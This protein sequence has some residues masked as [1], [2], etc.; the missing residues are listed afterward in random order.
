MPARLI[1]ARIL[2]VLVALGVFLLNSGYRLLPTVWLIVCIVAWWIRPR[3]RRVWLPLVALAGWVLVHASPY[4][5]S[6]QTR[7]GGPRFVELVMGYPSNE[8]I[9]AAERGE[10]ILGGCL[11]THLEPRWILVW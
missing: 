3:W 11:V 6:W 4:D 1:V 7:P 5:V 10:V 2:W 9:R 8:T